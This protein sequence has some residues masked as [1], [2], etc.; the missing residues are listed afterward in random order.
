MSVKIT[1]DELNEAFNG[2]Y[3]I[4][5]EDIMFGYF[6]ISNHKS[7]DLGRIELMKVGA[8]SHWCLFL[9]KDCYLSPGYMDEVREVQRILGN[10]S[11]NEKYFKDREDSK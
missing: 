8:W 10:K 6:N 7:E 2:K 4:I 3:L 9:E 5:E 1:W 11:H